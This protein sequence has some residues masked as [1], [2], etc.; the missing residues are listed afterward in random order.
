MGKAL[1]TIVKPTTS[2]PIIGIADSIRNSMDLRYYKQIVSKLNFIT[3]SKGFSN[4]NYSNEERI[5]N[6]K[7]TR[8]EKTNPKVQLYLK[9]G[10]KGAIRYYIEKIL[11]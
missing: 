3:Q 8:L 11:G 7:L 5:L 2:N 9:R 4:R 10:S 1:I 6:E